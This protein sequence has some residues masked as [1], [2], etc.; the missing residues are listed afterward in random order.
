MTELLAL[1]SP[2]SSPTQA[3]ACQRAD[4]LT[5]THLSSLSSAAFILNPY[6]SLPKLGLLLKY[7]SVRQ[8]GSV[9]FHPRS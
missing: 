4:T 7:P 8:G 1:V 3:Y 2:T 6:Q 9:M 5:V